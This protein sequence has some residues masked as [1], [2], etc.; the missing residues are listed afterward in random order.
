MRTKN[1]GF[2][3]TKYEGLGPSQNKKTVTK[4]MTKAQ[5]YVH[6]EKVGLLSLS[7]TLSQ[8]SWIM[9]YPRNI[10]FLHSCSKF[11]LDYELLQQNIRI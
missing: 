2:A 4:N 6:Y 9:K 8:I 11:K 10:F 5:K 3:R 7:L 1:E